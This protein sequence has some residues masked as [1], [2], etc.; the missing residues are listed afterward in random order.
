MYRHPASW[1]PLLLLEPTETRN[2]QTRGAFLVIYRLFPFPLLSLAFISNFMHS[3][4]VLLEHL[5]QA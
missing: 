1:R 3:P 5:C 2:F 4:T